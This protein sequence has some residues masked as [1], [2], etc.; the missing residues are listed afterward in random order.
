MGALMMQLMGPLRHNLAAI[1]EMGGP[2]TPSGETCKC[3]NSE[4]QT[5]PLR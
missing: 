4:L 1:C 3:S 5:P 2:V